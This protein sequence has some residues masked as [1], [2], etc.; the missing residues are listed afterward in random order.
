MA[1]PLLIGCDLRLI[2]DFTLNL[3]KNNEV[4]AVNQDP[5]GIQ[6]HRVY[7]D[8]EKQIEV[9]ARPLNDGS[10]AIGL[11]NLGEEQQSISI[12][13]DK[14]SI[15]GKQIVRNLWKQKDMGIFDNGYT[16]NVP[17]HGTIFIKITPYK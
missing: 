11:F 16:A 6:G 1:A 3:L 2:D 8:E 4:I 13:W 5:A 12:T 14:L 9:W 7:F 17:S 10:W 15:S